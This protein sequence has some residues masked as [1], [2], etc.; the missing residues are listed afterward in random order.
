MRQKN[1]QPFLSAT[2]SVGKKEKGTDKT[3]KEVQVEPV[4]LSKD[5]C[6]SSAEAM[7]RGHVGLSVVDSCVYL[8]S[9]LLSIC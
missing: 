3:I 5:P 4:Y 6:K 9:T 8:L 2:H 7:N 1:T